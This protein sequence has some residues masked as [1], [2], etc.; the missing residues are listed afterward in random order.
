ME[1]LLIILICLLIIAV[2]IVNMIFTI[3]LIKAGI[4]EGGLVPVSEDMPH[5]LLITILSPVIG[6]FI[7]LFM[8]FYINFHREEIDTPGT[9]FN[10]MFGDPN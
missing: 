5:P 1:I 3:T 9:D 8:L 10:E 6:T 7:I 4:K 2:F